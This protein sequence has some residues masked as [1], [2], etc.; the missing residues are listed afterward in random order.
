MRI[1][2][3]AYAPEEGWEQAHRGSAR[4]QGVQKLR[5][6]QAIRVTMTCAASLG[7][8]RLA[9]WRVVVM[10]PQAEEPRRQ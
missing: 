10:R 2:I 3:A 9:C 8:S 7:L 4:G 5:C 1:T 6:S